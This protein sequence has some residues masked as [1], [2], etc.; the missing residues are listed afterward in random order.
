MSE[1]RPDN[2]EERIDIESQSNSRSSD[3]L[4]HSDRIEISTDPMGDNRSIPSEKKSGQGRREQGEGRQQHAP[5][6]KLNLREVNMSSS[7]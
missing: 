7:E 5:S 4:I 2:L 1:E 3:W 6:G